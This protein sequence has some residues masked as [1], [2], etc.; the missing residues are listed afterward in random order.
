MTQRQ[1]S[2]QPPNSRRSPRTSPSRIPEPA[3]ELDALIN[4]QEGLRFYRAQNYAAALEQFRR[5]VAIAP[6]NVEYR[7]NY[8]L[9][10]LQLGTA[11]EAAREFVRV[12]RQNPNYVEAHFN[13]A[14]ARLAVGD[15]L[16]AIESLER[17]LELSTDPRQQ[18]IAQRRLQDVERA[19]RETA[20]PTPG[21]TASLPALRW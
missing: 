19:M 10:L 12:V 16:D 1:R 11:G 7:H 4:N 17:V 21:D 18:G 13:L 14:Q 3:T 2:P 20:P 6:S 8:A 5:A 9:T 15:T